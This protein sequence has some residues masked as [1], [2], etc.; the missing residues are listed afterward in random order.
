MSF[1]ASCSECESE[2]MEAEG[3]A[4]VLYLRRPYE[5]VAPPERDVFVVSC[6]RKQLVVWM[7]GKAPELSSVTEDHLERVF[8]RVMNIVLSAQK[9][10][11]SMQK[12]FS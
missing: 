5:L 8:N 2:R 7:Y 12:I 11:N 3:D 4:L 6:S 1:R 10:L 9:I